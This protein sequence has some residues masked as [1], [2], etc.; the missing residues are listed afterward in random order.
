MLVHTNPRYF[1]IMYNQIKGGGN[2]EKP[3]KK[4]R[5]ECCVFHFVNKYYW[6]ISV[7]E[8]VQKSVGVLVAWRMS[9]IPDR[10]RKG[11]GG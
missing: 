6:G 5:L 3:T 9:T 10:T 4:F 11:S 1:H 7:L 2:L 8:V